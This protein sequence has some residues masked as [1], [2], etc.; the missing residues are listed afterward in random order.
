VPIA[1]KAGTNAAFLVLKKEKPEAF[2]A[3]ARYM[4]NKIGLTELLRYDCFKPYDHSWLRSPT[5]AEK[6]AVTG[7]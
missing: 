2:V 6:K 4:D 7:L 5:P 3:L 1:V